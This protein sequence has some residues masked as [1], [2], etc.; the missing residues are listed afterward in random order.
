[1]HYLVNL[2][3]ESYILTD[4]IYV[5][6]KQIDTNRPSKYSKNQTI[7]THQFK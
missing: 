5:K 3:I 6:S 2:I 7:K 4:P 1:M